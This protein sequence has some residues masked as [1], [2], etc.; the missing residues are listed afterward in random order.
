MC[1]CFTKSQMTSGAPMIDVTALIGIVNS[2][3]GSC[4]IISQ[5]NIKIAPLNKTEGTKTK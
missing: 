1:L 4:A 5:I 3:K 2:E